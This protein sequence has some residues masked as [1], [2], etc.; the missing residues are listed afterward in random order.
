MIYKN[1]IMKNILLLLAIYSYSVNGNAQKCIS[2]DCVNGYGVQITPN[3]VHW[4]VDSFNDKYEGQFVNGLRDGKGKMSYSYAIK[5]FLNGIYEGDWSKGLYNGFGVYSYPSALWVKVR[6]VKYEGNWVDGRREGSGKEF[7]DYGYYDGNWE[8]DEYSGLGTHYYKDGTVIKGKWKEGKLIETYENYNT[9]TGKFTGKLKDGKKSGK[10][11]FYLED[12]SIL[13][14]KFEDDH[15][16]G[17][18]KIT[19]NDGAVYEGEIKDYKA[20]GKGKTIKKGYHHKDDIYIG[21]Y[22][23][24]K[25]NGIGSKTWSNDQSFVGEWKNGNPVYGKWYQNYGKTFLIEGT[26]EDRNVFVKSSNDEYDR[27]LKQRKAI[28]NAENEAKRLA[29]ENRLS[30]MTEEEKLIE[31]FRCPR[32]NGKGTLP[33]EGTGTTNETQKITVSGNVME[34]ETTKTKTDVTQCTCHMCN[35]KK[36]IKTE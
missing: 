15:L 28:I 9:N 17:N 1:F 5:K 4:S 18:G 21:N 24:G 6:D 30:S 31:K 13:E 29:E 19:Y 7:N 27:Y 34:V 2:G 11:Q 25:A 26:E 36:Y 14:G 20:S 32:C 22:L 33:C 23:N 8:A 16:V 3:K 10:G 35:G 12:G